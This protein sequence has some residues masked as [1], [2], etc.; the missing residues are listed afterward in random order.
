M[1]IPTPLRDAVRDKLMEQR[2]VPDVS[3]LARILLRKVV[4]GEI[5]VT[6]DDFDADKKEMRGNDRTDVTEG[7]LDGQDRTDGADLGSGGAG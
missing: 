7:N 5:A 1:T 3:A 4:A 2:I 6:Q